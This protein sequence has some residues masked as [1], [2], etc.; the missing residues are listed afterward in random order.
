MNAIKSLMIVMAVAGFLCVPF[1][2]QAATLEELDTAIESYNTSGDIS[3]ATIYQTLV[4]LVDEALAATDQYAEDA[5]RVAIID[6]CN[7]FKN[8]GITEVAASDLII[9]AGY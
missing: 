8:L 4:D 2:S 3:D 5:L 6:M 9:K 1:A 7:T